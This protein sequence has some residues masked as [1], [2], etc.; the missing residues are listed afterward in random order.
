MKQS[1]ESFKRTTSSPHQSANSYLCDEGIKKLSSADCMAAR[2]IGIFLREYRKN[3]QKEM[4][5]LRGYCKMLM[6]EA[7]FISWLLKCEPHS[8]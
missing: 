5:E 2:I 1:K 3:Q 4:P 8:S 6:I 7:M